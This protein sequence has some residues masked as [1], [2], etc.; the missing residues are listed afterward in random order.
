MEI[1]KPL[2]SWRL[3]YTLVDVVQQLTAMV[4][5]NN[6]VYSG[7]EGSRHASAAFAV[8]RAWS[9]HEEADGYISREFSAG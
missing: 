4:R 9:R 2:K 8:P 5:S 3:T 7:Y 6:G 1:T